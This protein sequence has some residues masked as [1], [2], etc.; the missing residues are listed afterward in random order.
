MSFKGGDGTA[1]TKDVKQLTL[2]IEKLGGMMVQ[3]IST[4]EQ[5]IEQTAAKMDA[6]IAEL[7]QK[8]YQV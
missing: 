5:K 2:D 7:R 3:M 4:V 6:L 8:G 1:T